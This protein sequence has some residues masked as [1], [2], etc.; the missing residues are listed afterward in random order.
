MYDIPFYD[1]DSGDPAPPV[2]NVIAVSRR[3]KP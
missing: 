3:E 2:P 1:S